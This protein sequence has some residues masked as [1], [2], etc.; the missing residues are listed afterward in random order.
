MA[1]ESSSKV[2]NVE[3]I[4]I[5]EALINQKVSNTTTVLTEQVKN[6]P[7]QEKEF[8]HVAPEL[9]DRIKNLEIEVLDLKKKL[10]KSERKAEHFLDIVDLAEKDV[11]EKEATN[12]ELRKQIE[13][14]KKEFKAEIKSLQDQLRVVV[15]ENSVLNSKLAN[16][17]KQHAPSLE[18]DVSATQAGDSATTMNESTSSIQDGNDNIQN[19]VQDDTTTKT[20][21]IEMN[22]EDTQVIDVHEKKQLF[23]CNICRKSFKKESTKKRHMSTAH[24]VKNSYDCNVCKKSFT[25]AHSMRRHVAIVH[26][27]QRPFKCRICK[28]TFTQKGHMEQHIS[29]VHEG[30]YRFNC[31]LCGRLFGQKPQ[32]SS[33][34]CSVRK[35]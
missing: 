30:K 12:R 18:L 3:D 24:K 8:D 23:K 1:S 20:N 17:T 33:H 31:D 6:L 35:N 22:Q 4:D 2:N 11:I 7:S 27:R 32:L 21:D 10:S 16:V 15:K 26:E 13:A 19:E 28:K 9:E 29:I 25:F 34:K 14:N 5:F